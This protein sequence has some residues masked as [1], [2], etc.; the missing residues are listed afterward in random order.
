MILRGVK[1]LDSLHAILAVFGI[2]IGVLLVDELKL[3]AQL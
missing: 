2:L 3:F 1:Y